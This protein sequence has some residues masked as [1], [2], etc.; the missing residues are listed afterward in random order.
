MKQ[1]QECETQGCQ[2]YLCMW[3][4]Q[5]AHQLKKKKGGGGEEG[6][7]KGKKKTSNNDLRREINLLIITAEMQVNW[8][9]CY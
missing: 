8:Y 6:N 9:W 1:G 3:Q 2:S 5:Q 7:K 4:G